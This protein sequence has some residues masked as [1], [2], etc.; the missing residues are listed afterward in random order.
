MARLSDMPDWMRDHFLAMRDKAPRFPGTAWANGPALNRRR[1]AIV[2]TAGL[3]QAGDRPFTG[4]AGS[5]EYRVIPAD[6]TAAELV[7]SHRS[8]NFDRTGF[9]GDANLVFPI[10]RLKELAAD[11]EIGSVAQYH[12]SFMGAVVPATRFE[13]SARAVAGLL[14]RDGVDAAILTPV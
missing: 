2:S 10:D 11:G 13:A 1:V 5:T 8:V 7:M 14:K 6:A 4:G 3:H 9:R 12:Y